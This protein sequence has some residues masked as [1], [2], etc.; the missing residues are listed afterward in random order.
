MNVDEII[1]EVL[2][3]K[4]YA[5]IDP[6]VIRRVCTETV[7]K[8]QKQKE[9]IKAVKN[10]LHI[11]HESF[12][13]NDWYK[14]AQSLLS[15]LPLCFDCSHLIETSVKIMQ[16]HTST[17]ERLGDI[18]EIC[19]FLDCYITKDS[20]VIDIG[21]G[22]NPF[23]LPLLSEYPAAYY[24]YD[25]SSEEIDIL[26]KYF[27][28][29]KKGKYIAT[30]LDAVVSTPQEKVDVAFLFKLLPLLQQQKKGRAFSIL[31]DLNFSKAIVSFPT[32]SIGGKHKG[33]EAFY[34]NLFEEN[35]S[36][37]FSVI[38]KQTFSNEMFYVI[39]KI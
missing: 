10:E 31:E 13:Q 18:K 34:S 14:N 27:T 6:S 36:S 12:M 30:L 21:C 26:N 23:V 38:E 1:A 22:L 16:S 28:V 25:I 8:Y 20:S 19:S 17:R 15:Q 11:I 37:V 2:S 29:L 24:A 32:K 4:K 39:K 35:L 5:S 9:V 3:S 7:P 33:M